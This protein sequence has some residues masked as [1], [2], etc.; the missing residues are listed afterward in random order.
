MRDDEARAG[1]VYPPA[2][3]ERLRQVKQRYD[4]TNV[5]HHNLNIEPA[6]E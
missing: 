1:E 2:T 3:L 5:F 4:P 6:G